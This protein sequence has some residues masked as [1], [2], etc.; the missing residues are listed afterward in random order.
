M[1]TAAV[2]A[3]KKMM[4]TTDAYYRCKTNACIL[5]MCSQKHLDL[6]A[7]TAD[8]FCRKN[9]T[10][11]RDELGYNGC[12]YI[13]IRQNKMRYADEIEEQVNANKKSIP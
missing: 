12:N 9:L 8:S 2:F 3:E 13:S 5:L 4:Y 7:G 10:E 6:Q 11:T 1:Y